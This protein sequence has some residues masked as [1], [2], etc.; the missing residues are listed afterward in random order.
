MHYRNMTDAIL[1]IAHMDE[2]KRKVSFKLKVARQLL[3]KFE[4][5]GNENQREVLSVIFEGS[6]PD[7]IKN[8]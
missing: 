2:K 8:E 7:K 3:S 4:P 1:D 5:A 6:T